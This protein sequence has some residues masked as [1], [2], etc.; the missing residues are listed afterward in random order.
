[1]RTESPRP[2]REQVLGG[3]AGSNDVGQHLGD[4]EECVAGLLHEPV[5]GA[6]GSVVADVWEV[7]EQLGCPSP[8]LGPLSP[9]ERVDCV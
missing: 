9:R 5:D 1:M 4:R 7:C 6:L 2:F 3:L 8:R